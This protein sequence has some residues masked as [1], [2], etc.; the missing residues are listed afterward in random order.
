[1]VGYKI[2]EVVAIAE[3]TRRTIRAQ[4]KNVSTD[5]VGIHLSLRFF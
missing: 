1:M 4:A 5:I 2:F 3:R